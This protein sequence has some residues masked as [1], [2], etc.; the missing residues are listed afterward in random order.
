MRLYYLY[1]FVFFLIPCELVVELLIV[2]PAVSRAFE[3]N[4]FVFGVGTLA[5]GVYFGGYSCFLGVGFIYGIHVGVLQFLGIVGEG[6]V[7][8]SATNC[9]PHF[10]EAL[11]P[12]SVTLAS[13]EVAF[14]GGKFIV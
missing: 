6:V 13:F 1:L 7:D 5:L 14:I 2:L 4:V 10:Q 12:F 8:K 9:E 3:D 11:F